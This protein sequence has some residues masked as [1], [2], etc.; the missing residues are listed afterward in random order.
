M[1]GGFYDE[2]QYHIGAAARSGW[3]SEIDRGIRLTWASISL[4]LMGPIARNIVDLGCADGALVNYLQEHTLVHYTGVEAFEPFLT[5]AKAKHPS[6]TWILGDLRDFTSPADVVVAIGTT[7]GNNRATALHEI[8]DFARRSCAQ[9][10]VVT[11]PTETGF[12][13]AILAVSPPGLQDGWHRTFGP[14]YAGEVWWIDAIDEVAPVAPEL[15]FAHATRLVDDT[16]GSQ[17]M[18]AA[19]LGLKDELVRI[20]REHP[21]D[22]GVRLALD[23]FEMLR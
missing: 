1:V 2:K 20:A 11:G 19:R 7:V 16:V 10:I 18:V 3:R 9:A 4:D 23:Y 13:E 22:E 17:A 6:Q 8:Y 12:D 5:A 21:N 14:A 15:C